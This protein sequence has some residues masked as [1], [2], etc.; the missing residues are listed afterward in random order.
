MKTISPL[1]L[2]VLSLFYS[3]IQEKT[4]DSYLVNVDLTKRDKVSMTDLFSSIELIPLETKE[5][6]LIKRIGKVVSFKDRYYVFDPDLHVIYVFNSQGR[7]QC[8]IGKYGD[9][10]ED[11]YNACDFHLDKSNESIQILSSVGVLYYYDLSGRFI[12][13]IKLPAESPVFSF[14]TKL[15]D[16]LILLW[17]ANVKDKEQLYLY[18][19]K[20]KKYLNHLYQNKGALNAF[21]KTVFYTYNGKT[22]FHKPFYNQ[23][24][25]FQS[26]EIIKDYAWDFGKNT[27]EIE[28][29][30]L[31]PD[32]DNEGIKTM[33]EMLRTGRIPYFYNIQAQ[34]SKY[35]YTQVVFDLKNSI[36][37]FYNKQTNISYVFETF[38]ENTYA[39]FLY[40]Q[41]DCILGVCNSG[42]YTKE[43]VLVEDVLDQNNL[44]KLQSINEEDN[45]C[46][47]KYV[48]K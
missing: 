30:Q 34:N 13:R 6:S 39:S 23:V 27:L 37:V 18:S 12:E 28:E 5:E 36:N 35:Y 46:L 48:L 43:R 38:T 14:F 29:Y 2:L 15:T 4:N 17:T 22:Y 10:P 20:D 31:P 8:Q 1:L 25:T 19:I 41:D 44:I 42:Y 32:N 47:V 33:V 9:G 3:C 40:W 21:A 11:Y 16:D 24:Y 45:P 26:Q 7:F